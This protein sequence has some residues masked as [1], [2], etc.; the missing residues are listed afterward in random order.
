MLTPD[1]RILL[2]QAQEP[3][4]GFRV[5]F[6][7]G[8]GIEPGESAGTCLRRELHEETGLSDVEIGPFIWRRHH[9]FEWDNQML[10]QDEEFYLLPVEQFEPEMERNPSETELMVFRQFEWW[11]A[12][13]ISA[14]DDEFAPRL[15]AEHLES[16]IRNGP[17]ERPIDVGV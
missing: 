13:E 7:P 3:V 10:S 2:M 8:G 4:R 6:T 5:W 16:L 11:T 1:Q 9:T 17:P 12:Q 14:S 15:L